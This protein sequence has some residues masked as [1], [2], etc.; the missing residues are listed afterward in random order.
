MAACLSSYLHNSFA[1]P[2]V[3]PS[4][5]FLGQIVSSLINI[6]RSA[7]EMMIDSH[8]GGTTE[9][10]RDGKNFVG[11]LAGIDFVLREGAGGADGEEFCCDAHKTREQ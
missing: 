4:Q 11:R 2:L 6:F 7:G 5:Q 1:K 10:I 9:I 3:F 8:F